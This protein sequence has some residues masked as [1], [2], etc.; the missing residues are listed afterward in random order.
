MRPRDSLLDYSGTGSISN[1]GSLTA[2]SL[3][4]I[5]NDTGLRRVVG[6]YAP[7]PSSLL[8]LAAGAVL[9]RRRRCGT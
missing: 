1:F 9:L 7:E 5:T 2:S 8:L 3:W 6:V 4:A